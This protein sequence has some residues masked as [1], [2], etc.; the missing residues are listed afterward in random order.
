VITP[1]SSTAL[2]VM[3][4]PSS[5]TVKWMEMGFYKGAPGRV[6]EMLV[7]RDVTEPEDAT[8]DRQPVAA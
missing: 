5:T 1:G 4:A 3:K 7:G 2:A 6:R 8:A